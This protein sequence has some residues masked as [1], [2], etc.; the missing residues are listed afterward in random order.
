MHINVASTL[1][2]KH[3]LAHTVSPLKDTVVKL[4]DPPVLYV[5]V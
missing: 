5:I 1:N 2:F 4:E 3:L